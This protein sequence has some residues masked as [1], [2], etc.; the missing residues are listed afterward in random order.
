MPQTLY[1]FSEDPTIESFRPH[2]A[3]GKEGKPPCVWAIDEAY[4]PLYWFPRDCPRITFWADK[5]TS[6]ADRERFLGLGTAKRVHAIESVWLEKVRTCKL[7]VY[8][9][10]ANPFERYPEACG[11]H[12]AYTEVVPLRC[13]RVGDLLERHA[14]AGIELRLTPSLWPLQRAVAA[15]SLQ[16]SMCRMR[17][18][19]PPS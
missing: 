13:E 11:Y 7:Y 10:D 19:Q 2:H 18:A 16:F 8:S 15:S 1:H 5:G 4:A 3:L 9:F 17:N 12:V 14:E 6:E